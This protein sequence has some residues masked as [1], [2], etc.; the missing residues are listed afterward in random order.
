[1][2]E[3]DSNMPSVAVLTTTVGTAEDAHH[4]AREAVQSRLAACVQ[5]EQIESHYIWQGSLC[6]EPEWRLVFKTLPVG[7]LALTRWLRGAHPHELPQ[8]LTREEQA[9]R[10]YAAWVEDR[11]RV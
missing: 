1:M 9:S 10:E 11:L 4:L 6:D 2:R 5:I 3:L 7:M 8:I